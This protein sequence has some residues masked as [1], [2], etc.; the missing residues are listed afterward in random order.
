[1]RSVTMKPQTGCLPFNNPMLSTVPA[2][3]VIP[4][5]YACASARPVFRTASAASETPTE[6]VPSTSAV[7]DI[8]KE[9]VAEKAREGMHRF[10]ASTRKVRTPY[11][12]SSLLHLPSSCRA[13][14]YAS[15]H[16]QPPRQLCRLEQLA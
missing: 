7:A 15:R 9:L 12:G 8:D 2:R 6:H 11:T 3:M 10:A 1:M 5:S 14:P 4:F 13:H 16:Y